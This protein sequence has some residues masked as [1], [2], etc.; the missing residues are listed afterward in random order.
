[1]HCHRFSNVVNCMNSFTS[2]A[3]WSACRDVFIQELFL[4]QTTVGCVCSGHMRTEFNKLISIKLS[5]QM[6]EA[7]I[8]E[9]KLAT[10]VLD[11]TF[12]NASGCVVKLLSCRRDGVMV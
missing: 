4:L 7:L 1:M 9:T 11:V 12:F 10:F 8:Y 5:S 3:S 6:D 2:I